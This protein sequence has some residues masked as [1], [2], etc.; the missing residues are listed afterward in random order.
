[1]QQVIVTLP[2]WEIFC[3]EKH[4]TPGKK[5]RKNDFSPSEKY[6]CY[7]SACERSRVRFLD[8]TDVLHVH[9]IL[10]PPLESFF[11]PAMLGGL[12]WKLA[13]VL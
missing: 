12:Q 1:M 5:I 4:F 2:K 10:H 13:F 9:F 3:R 11:T 6:A 8:P 7:A